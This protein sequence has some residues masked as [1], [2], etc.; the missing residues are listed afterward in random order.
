MSVTFPLQLRPACASVRPGAALFIP[1]DSPAGWI[2]EI[3]T[4]D[5][6]TA[7]AR[8]YVLPRSIRD[9]RPLGVLVTLPRL[10]TIT[11]RAL[12]YGLI[13]AKLYLPVEASLAPD[14]SSEELDQRLIWELQVL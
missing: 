11:H 13:G 1:G 12:P 9:P 8:L 2:D 14:A 6:P 4:W 5:V 3:A 10:P 7:D